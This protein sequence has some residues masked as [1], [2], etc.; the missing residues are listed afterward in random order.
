MDGMA[1]AWVAHRKFNDSAEYIAADDRI[2]LPEYVIKHEDLANVE[3]YILDFSYPREVLLELEKKVKKL[4]IL[5]HHFSAKDAVEAVKL[6]VYSVEDSGCKITWKY[7]FP[8]EKI[9]V[10][11]N[12]VSARDTWSN[13]MPEME[14]I[15]NYIYRTEKPSIEYVQQV[16]EEL[17]KENSIERLAPLGKILYEY[18]ESLVKKYIGLAE[19]IQFANY[20]VYAV[21]APSDLKSDL[22]NALAKLTNTFGIVYY[23]KEGAWRISLRSVPDFDV[24]EIAQRFGGGGHKNSAAFKIDEL[25]PIIRNIK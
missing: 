8:D 20:E 3:I 23:Y 14:A 4:V 24:S 12:Y 2:N 25:N 9:P 5:D 1:S 13:D 6:H 17:E 16:Y 7:F 10:I 11:I 21:N 19:K 18:R 15:S 22:G